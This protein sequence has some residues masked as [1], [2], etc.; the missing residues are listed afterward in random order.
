MPAFTTRLNEFL[1]SAMVESKKV[2]WPSRQELIESTQ[3]VVVATFI[4][5]IFLFVVDRMFGFLL[6]LF[7]R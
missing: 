3:V 5:M 1:Q 6:G 7:M 4:V 2:T